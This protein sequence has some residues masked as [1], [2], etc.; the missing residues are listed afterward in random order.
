[1]NHFYKW[2]KISEAIGRRFFLLQTEKNTLVIHDE[3]SDIGYIH[4][5]RLFGDMVHKYRNRSK[6]FF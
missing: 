4:N 1:M 3:T 6:Y 5:K 2:I